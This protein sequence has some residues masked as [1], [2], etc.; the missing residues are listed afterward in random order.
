MMLANIDRAGRGSAR[1]TS[2]I[3][4]CLLGLVIGRG[5]PAR[6]QVEAEFADE[7]DADVSAEASTDSGGQASGSTQAT[8]GA[9]AA[10]EAPAPAAA[11]APA[12]Q[13][14]APPVPHEETGEEVLDD[15]REQRFR[16]QNTF[17][18]PSGGFWAVDANSG[19]VGSFRLH[20]GVDYFVKD[21]FLHARDQNSWLGG[22]LSISG[23]VTSYLELFAAIEN[24]AHTN[25]LGD[26]QL[27]QVLGDTTLG[28]K[29]FH[30]FTP[31]LTLGA[32]FRVQVLNAVGDIGPVFDGASYGLRG[33]F[34]T[35][36]RGLED[37]LPLITR[38][39][40]DYFFDNSANLIEAV[41][42]Q[43]YQDLGPSAREPVGT[44][45]RHLLTRVER[46]AL[47]INRLD[48]L[49]FTLGLEM[50]LHAGG[51]V[52]IHPL[53]EWNLSIPVNRQGYSCLLLATA[54]GPEDPTDGCLDK[55]GFAAMP[56]TL[57]LGARLHPGPRGLSFGL[58]V[59]IGLSGTS[60]FVRELAANRSYAV[61]FSMGYAVDTTGMGPARV[62]EVEVVREVARPA[63]ERMRIA[64]LVV[65]RES[66]V[67][68]DGAS[69]RYAG[70]DL[71]TQQTDG[72]GR[73]VSY[74]MEAGTVQLELAHPD[75]ESG[76]CNVTVP[77]P[78]PAAPAAQ[79]AAGA[80]PGQTPVAA[81]PLGTAP[82]PAGAKGGRVEVR[83]ELVAQPKNGDLRGQL[84][85]DNGQ[86]VAGARVEIQGPK[87][88]SLSSDAA[89]AF[90]APDLPNGS[91]SARV[92]AEGYLLKLASFEVSAGQTAT[93]VVQ[94]SPKPKNSKVRVTKREVRVR[95]KI[96]FNTNSDELQARS[97]ALL[98]EIADVL[99]RNPQLRLIE[100]QGHTDN[101]GNPGENLSLS[102]RRAESVQQ[103]LISAGVAA[104]RLTAK[105]YGDTRPL[106]PNLTDANRARNRRVQFMIREQD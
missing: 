32:D 44:E 97:S 66:G 62:Q 56:S 78:G 51:R 83:C 23:T 46:F 22:T 26:P 101:R 5:A 65:D 92:E 61:L 53:A 70:L 102:Q 106:I 84:N 43:R 60:V 69:V 37:P 89:G 90:A 28:I 55:E 41:E 2:L 52:F 21:D 49:S 91:Y 58:G 59:D 17:G 71:T 7:F 93:P 47:G 19:P 29:A 63:P 99:M 67:G 39:S 38:F 12:G 20:I 30:G 4:L 34:S 75:Y 48:A 36:L 25:T 104:E 98:S 74:G 11:A 3:T 68:I 57:T 86:P 33:L 42:A 18:G 54:T 31:W 88:L 50:P 100:V 81:A 35:D 85:D 27:L 87:N 13:Y 72:E 94:L 45:D 96:F 8:A 10:T 82:S 73:F 24:H 77:A 1:T 80:Q 14:E 16:T 6:A 105:G 64:G 76:N 9:G 95:E 40:L 15:G 79:P 103:W